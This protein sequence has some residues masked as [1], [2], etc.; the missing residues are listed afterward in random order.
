MPAVAMPKALRDKP[1]AH[2]HKVFCVRER[3]KRS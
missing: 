2:T 1:S 3:W